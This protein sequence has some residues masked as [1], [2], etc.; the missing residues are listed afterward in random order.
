[1]LD[2]NENVFLLDK[3]EYQ[4]LVNS[5]TIFVVANLS[6]TMIPFN[7]L[8]E[9][10]TNDSLYH[11]LNDCINRNKNLEFVLKDNEVIIS[12]TNY[13]IVSIVKALA[14][15]VKNNQIL[16]TEKMLAKLHYLSKKVDFKAFIRINHDKNFEIKIDNKIVNIAYE[17]ILSI[18]VNTEKY[19]EFIGDFKKIYNLTKE[20]FVFCLKELF[21]KENILDC[22]LLDENEINRYLYLEN[23]YDTEAINQLIFKDK[24]V[25]KSISLNDK[26][27]SAVY[28][29]IP[30]NK[31]KLEQSIYIYYSLTQILIYDEEFDYLK[32]VVKEHKDLTRIEAITPK[33]NKVI[34]YEFAIIFAKFLD[35]MGINYKLTDSYMQ[36]RVKKYLFKAKLITSEFTYDKTSIEKMLKG[37]IVCNQLKNT[38]KEFENILQAVYQDLYQKRLNLAIL[39]MSYKESVD[40]YKKLSHKIKISFKDKLPILSL[41]IANTKNGSDIGYIYQLR[42]IL[43]TESE[44]TSNINI[45]TVSENVDGSMMPIVIITTNEV[46]V[47]LYNS[48]HYIYYNPPFPL[49]DYNLSEL[50][51]EFFRG[52]FSYIKGTKENIIGLEKSNV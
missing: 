41:L 45:I 3:K 4:K 40:N 38:K 51:K 18:L 24:N 46:N 28:K 14:Q 49:K 11:Y 1:M 25:T 31:T 27:I 21:K 13:S 33:N 50:R 20:E 6:K 26:L 32:K 39:G 48:N 12:R 36:I 16:V 5:K 7:F 23:N 9:V 30:S 43:F 2:N 17:S 15:V 47:N 8:N 19:L 44:L 29:S 35:Q 10:L 37:I 52:R 42:K 34:N 22:Y